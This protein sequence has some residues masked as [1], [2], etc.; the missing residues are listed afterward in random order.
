MIPAVA[1]AGGQLYDCR[2]TQR[3]PESDWVSQRI[4]LVV[5]EAGDVTVIDSVL[6]NFDQSPK[7]AEAR[8]RGAT[9]AVT[10]GVSNVLDQAQQRAQMRYSA[11][12]DTDTRAIKVTARPTGF[13]QSFRG[14]G[15]C[16]AR[17]E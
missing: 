7:R 6:I 2:I 15:T 16:A 9:L 11:R 4:A 14:R 5:N 10:W 12:L 17:S 13:A 1:G 3:S 8:R